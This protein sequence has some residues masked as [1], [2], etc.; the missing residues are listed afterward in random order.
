MIVLQLV[1]GYLMFFKNPP[2]PT[3][4]TRFHQAPFVRQAPTPRLKAT[5]N[6]DEKVAQREREEARK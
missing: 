6:S 5:V 1:L 4:E 2:K 3:I